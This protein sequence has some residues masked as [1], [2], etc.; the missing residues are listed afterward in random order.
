MNT[1]EITSGDIFV[2]GTAFAQCHASTLAALPGHRLI[3]AWFGGTAE[4]NPDTAIWVSRFDGAAWSAPD[5]LFKVAPLAHYNPVL[6]FAPD[7]RLHLWYKVGPN[8][9]EWRSWHAASD[10]LGHIWT[11]A[12]PFL[13]DDPLARGPVRCQPIVTPS[14]AWLA[15]ASDERLRDADGREWWCYIDRSDD[16]GRTWTAAPIRLAAGSPPGKGAIQ[17]TLWHSATGVHCLLRTSL[18]R[19]YRSDSSD[20]GRTWSPA[21]ATD[22]PNNNSGIAVARLSDG[23]LALLWNPVE[24]DWG[25]RTPLRLS[26]SSDDGATWS[27][28]CDLATGDGEF[29]YPALIVHDDRLSATWTN[30]RA[31]IAFWQSVVPT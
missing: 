17:P 24:K 2:P 1:S 22:L 12:Q 25:A 11:A 23:R 5:K 29:S 19:I 16:G 4:K 27:T 14:G 6:F 21:H 15:G 20:D 28:L 7:G 9:S 13:P 18:G 31:T 26:L 3:A 30:R 8:C 10:D